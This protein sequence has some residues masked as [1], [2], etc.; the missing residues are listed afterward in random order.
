MSETKFLIYLTPDDRIRHYHF[1]IKDKITKFAIQYEAFIID[2]WHPII[3]YDT[4]HGFAHLD[5][6][7]PDSSVE[8]VPLFYRDYNEALT[9]SQYD[10][11][12]NWEWYRERYER[13]MIK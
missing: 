3:R 9:Y 1:S 7:H 4:A 12:S 2:K 6:M 10:L 8:K 11:N 13:E 5:R